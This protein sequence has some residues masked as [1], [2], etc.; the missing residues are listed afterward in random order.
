MATIIGFGG[1]RSRGAP[2]RGSPDRGSPD[3]AWIGQRPARRRRTIGEVLTLGVIPRL[4]LSQDR[5]PAEPAIGDPLISA[6]DIAQLAPI[7]LNEPAP[8]LL[9]RVEAVMRRGVSA[10]EVFVDLLAP[11]AR[12][13]GEQWEEDRVDFV[14]VTMGL[15]RLQEVLRLVAGNT[16]RA[17]DPGRRAALFA[18]MPGDDHSFG[19]VMV[20]E[21]FD[22]AGWDTRLLVQPSQ[23]ALIDAVAARHFDLLGLTISCDCK[24]DRLL[25]LV[26]GLRSVSANPN[27]CI[28]I[29]GRVPAENPGLV[30]LVGADGTASTAPE[31]VALADRLVHVTRMAATA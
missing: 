24:V 13:M 5:P 12:W 4:L 29:G 11:I 27:L 7:A 10:Q 28:M 22:I 14:T 15:W 9:D 16:A 6:Q 19:A 30:A 23:K 2:D 21:C 17:D 3:E 8:T 25:S 31:A 18:P 1:K 20:Q 26:H